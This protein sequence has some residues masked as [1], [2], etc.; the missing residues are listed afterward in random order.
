MHVRV[1]SS[2]HA[3]VT[4]ELAWESCTTTHRCMP[5]RHRPTHAWLQGKVLKGRRS[6]VVIATKF[7]LTTH[8]PPNGKPE[9]VRECVEASLK[10]LQT[11]YIDL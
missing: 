4:V 10:R 8:S 9:Y 3:A 2:S 7:G 1:R 5:G 6:E 11:D